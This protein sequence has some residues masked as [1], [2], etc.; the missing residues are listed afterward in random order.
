MGED[1]ERIFDP[2]VHV[3]ALERR[4][5]ETRVA[6]ERT[7]DAANRADRGADRPRRAREERDLAQ[8]AGK[9]LQALAR[10]HGAQLARRTLAE[11]A[12]LGEQRR[13]DLAAG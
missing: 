11:L 6:L 10:G 13:G 3:D 4:F 7:D 12:D 1:D 5:I 9:R 8:V 2:R